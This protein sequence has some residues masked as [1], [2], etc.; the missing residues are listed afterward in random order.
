MLAI[1]VDRCRDLPGAGPQD[2]L[3]LGQKMKI[4]VQRRIAPFGRKGRRQPVEVAERLVHVGLFHFDIAHVDGRIAGDDAAIGVLAHHLRIDRH[5]LRHVDDEI[6]AHR[7]RAREPPPVLEV[8]Q[9]RI[10]L[11]LGAEGREMIGRG[12]D[13]V[14]G[15]LPLL[16]LD[17]TTPANAAPAAD[18]FH[19]DPEG[20]RRIQHR[21]ADRKPATLARGHEED[22]G[23]VCH[24]GLSGQAFGSP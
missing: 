16:H 14:L 12:G 6:A 15:E 19:I 24:A 20:A 23:V 21:G 17:L 22:E 11:F 7:G 9:G 8:A 18:A 5:V 3:Q 1:L 4:D 13:A 2:L 10:A